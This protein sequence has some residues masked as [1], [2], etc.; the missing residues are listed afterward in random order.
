MYKNTNPAEKYWYNEDKFQ[1][2]YNIFSTLIDEGPSEFWRMKKQGILDKTEIKSSITA[3]SE[4]TSR[5]LSK[6]DCYMKYN[7]NTIENEII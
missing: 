7:E 6:K 4:S 3:I 1:R 2:S 5:E